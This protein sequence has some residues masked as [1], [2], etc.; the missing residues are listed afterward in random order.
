MM[1]HL[2]RRDFLVAVAAAASTAAARAQTG[3]PSLKDACSGVFLIGTAFDFRTPTEFTPAEL[4]FITSQFNAVTPE[5]SMKP[6]PV[7][8]QEQSW[9]WAPAD[10]LVQFGQDNDI[11][12]FGHTLVWHSQTNPWLFEAAT[13]D[14]LLAR[15]EHHIH[16]IV[17]RYQGKMAGWDVVNEAIN[18]G[19]T[20]VREPA[21]VAVAEDCRS[22][23]PR[24]GVQIR[25]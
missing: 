24:P 15:L 20:G 8:P 19:E 7:H 2:S 13:R 12:I 22:R 3:V 18:D 25:T 10:A 21:R 9:N 11:R 1:R 6:G 5:N 16:T 4:D 17:G 23:L 14:V